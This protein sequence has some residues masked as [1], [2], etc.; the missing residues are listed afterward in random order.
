M[1]RQNICSYLLTIT[2]L[3]CILCVMSFNAVAQQEEP[4]A[5]TTKKQ[6]VVRRPLPKAAGGSRGFEKYAG[7]VASARL[8]VAAASRGESADAKKFREEGEALYR[9]GQYNQGIEAFKQSLRANQEQPAVY[10]DL[11]VIYGELQQHKEAVQAYQEA[12]RIKPDFPLAHLNLGNSYVD[13]GEYAKAIEAYKL[14]SQLQSIASRAYY[15]IGVAYT[16]LGQTDDAIKAYKEA[17]HLQ[18][19]F[20]AAHYNLGIAY[21]TAT[22]HKE[23]V[24]AFKEAIRLREGSEES[25]FTLDEARFNLGLALLHLNMKSEA[26][27]QYRV[28]KEQKSS[29]AEE[30]YRLINR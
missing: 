10:F 2:M 6:A 5:S 30:L 28:L 21:G 14:A 11:G 15:N 27:E 17:I 26:T 12:I 19:D 18:T 24:G 3:S 20:A 25:R 8:I 23:A 1:Y 22:L 4:K 29:L 9:S 13:L 7:R 16:E